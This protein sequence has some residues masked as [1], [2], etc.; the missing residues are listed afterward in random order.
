MPIKLAAA[1]EEFFTANN[2]TLKGRNIVQEAKQLFKR[3]PH[4]ELP[5]EDDF[6]ENG[7]YTLQHNSRLWFELEY[8]NSINIENGQ[9]Q[10]PINYYDYQGGFP[11]CW[12]FVARYF[13]TLILA[14]YAENEENNSR[15]NQQ[16]LIF[17]LHNRSWIEAYYGELKNAQMFLVEAFKLMQHWPPIEWRPD[18][19]EHL[20][21]V[22][23][24]IQ[25]KSEDEDSF[26]SK[27]GDINQLITT[28]L[29][30]SPDRGIRA[31]LE[32]C[33]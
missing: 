23:K 15:Y 13:N 10:Y 8:K 17:H 32:R 6:L 12:Y 16:A 27:Y 1:M 19:I 18:L 28:D 22:T 14:Y 20:A 5:Y 11:E 25:E 21:Q 9:R 2:I 4:F 29:I 24:L 3:F 33:S 30:G 31:L 26:V 7:I